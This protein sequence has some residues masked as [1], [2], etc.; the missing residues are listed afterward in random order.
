[1]SG[2]PA[3]DAANQANTAIVSSRVPPPLSS[4]S[5]PSSDQ[6][7]LELIQHPLFAHFQSLHRQEPE[8]KESLARAGIPIERDAAPASPAP[9]NATDAKYAVTIRDA[10]ADSLVLSH[11]TSL[12]LQLFP[13]RCYSSTYCAPCVCVSHDRA[14]PHHLP[15]AWRS[16]LLRSFMRCPHLVMAS[17]PLPLI[18]VCRVLLH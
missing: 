14:D 17:N 2:S 10:K 4:L 11:P 12:G 8:W 3:P 7:C 16:Q 6:F 15:P 9:A 5:L 13:E 18:R 1:M